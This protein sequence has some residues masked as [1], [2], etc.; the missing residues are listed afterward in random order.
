MYSQYGTIE[1]PNGELLTINGE[2][3]IVQP[4]HPFVLVSTDPSLDNERK[5]AKAFV[6]DLI[7]GSDLRVKLI[8][9]LPPKIGID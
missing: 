1:K 8:Y 7:D 3:E 6:D 4:G 2:E 9:V 5:L